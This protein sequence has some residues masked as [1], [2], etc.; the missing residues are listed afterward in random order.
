MVGNSID[1]SIKLVN[2]YGLST[3]MGQSMTNRWPHK[4]EK[5]RSSI[6][7]D[8]LRNLKQTSRTL[9]VR[10][11]AIPVFSTERIYPIACVL[12]SPTCLSLPL[13][14]IVSTQDI[15]VEAVLNTSAS[16]FCSN[17]C[18]CCWL[19]YCLQKYN[20]CFQNF[21]VEARPLYVFWSLSIDPWNKL[22]V[23]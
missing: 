18:W 23:C 19:F 1:Q 10:S 15:R 9:P 2:W 16:L 4:N 17:Y 5:N 6:A 14:D 8:W 12:Q 20:F 3:G 7:I 21:S 11:S 22:L 13:R